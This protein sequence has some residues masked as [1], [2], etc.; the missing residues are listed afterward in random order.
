MATTSRPDR[1]VNTTQAPRQDK[2]NR[3]PHER[4]ESSREQG[5][6]VRGVM[7]QAADDLEQGLV[8]TDLHGLRGAEQAVAPSAPSGQARPREQAGNGMRGQTKTPP[9]G[10][11]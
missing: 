5:A 9:R 7:Q 8:D 10:R 11:Q 2:E 3:L 4:D 1:R 6:P